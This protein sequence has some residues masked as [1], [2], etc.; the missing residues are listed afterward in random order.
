M[1]DCIITL[2]FMVSNIMKRKYNKGDSTLVEELVKLFIN[3]LTSMEEI[4]GYT[5]DK[6]SYMVTG[7]VFCLLNISKQMDD[8]GPLRNF[9][10]AI[11]EKAV[12]SVKN[13]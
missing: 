6:F 13:K 12:Q 4:L 2:F 1:E 5:E 7:N 11:N 8:F 10:D 3:N 9:C